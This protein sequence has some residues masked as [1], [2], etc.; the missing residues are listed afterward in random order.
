[1]TFEVLCVIVIG[2]LG[3]NLKW[4]NHTKSR[5]PIIDKTDSPPMRAPRNNKKV[6]KSMEKEKGENEVRRYENR[7]RVGPENV[8]GGLLRPWGRGREKM[9]QNT[10]NTLAVQPTEWK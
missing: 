9:R 3:V 5:W 8:G 10:T 1:L 6:N 7:G 2:V 4:K